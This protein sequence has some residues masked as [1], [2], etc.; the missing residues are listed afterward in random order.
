MTS[1]PSART[2]P[3]SIQPD[4]KSHLDLLYRT[5]GAGYLDSDP[6][7]FP[8]RFPRRE[9]REVVAFVTAALAYGRVAHIKMSVERLVRL[10]GPAPAA[11]VRG[12][13][14]REGRRALRG[15]VHRFND[16]G[17]VALLLYYVRQMMERSGS[18]ENFFMEGQADG[19]EDIGSALSS[20]V[21][22]ILELDC[23]PFYCSGKLPAGAGVR[24]FLPSPGDG[25]TCKRLNMFLRWM[26]RPDDGVDFGLWER[27]SP[28]RLVIPLDTHVSRIA[29]YIGLTRR[30]TVD[31]KMALDV[32]RS[33]RRLDAGDPVKYDFAL[34]RLGI[35]DSCP[36]RRN[37]FKCARCDLRLIC[38]LS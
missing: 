10:M 15:F 7:S 33:L 34:S 38:T 11:F 3:L 21:S 4:L 28:A 36:R 31:W 25:S 23:A 9:D 27:V 13:D 32:T 26:V 5:Y 24:F 14:P 16:G 17:D 37:P 29:S 22:R 19:Q 2:A 18:I 12:L 6:V 1:L 20:F 30:R 35:L 8:R